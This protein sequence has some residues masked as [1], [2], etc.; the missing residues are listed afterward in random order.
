MSGKVFVLLMTIAILGSMIAA[1]TVHERQVAC[2][3]KGGTLAAGVCV[4]ELK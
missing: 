3:K 2:D 1:S 4:K